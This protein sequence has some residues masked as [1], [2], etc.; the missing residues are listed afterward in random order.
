MNK[1]SFYIN[2]NKEIKNN[3]NSTH[4][5]NLNS[6]KI[7]NKNNKIDDNIKTKN[8]LKN[9]KTQINNNFNVNNN[10]NYYNFNYNQNNNENYMN[11]LNFLKKKKNNTIKGKINDINNKNKTQNEIFN[12]NI[13]E[14]SI[15]DYVKFNHDYSNDELIHTSDMFNSINDNNINIEHINKEN[16]LSKTKNKTNIIPKRKGISNANNLSYIKKIK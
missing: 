15:N 7:R 3:N 5:K 4:K 10:T 1:T 14:Y 9:R 12:D 8:E 16:L 2:K 11:K 6:A 13:E